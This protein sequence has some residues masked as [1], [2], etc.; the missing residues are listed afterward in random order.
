MSIAMIFQQP[1]LIEMDGR[2]KL[3]GSKLDT[4]PD[5]D[6]CDDVISAGLSWYLEIC[7]IILVE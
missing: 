2:S 4:Q 3:S 7:S 1:S 6:G 5:D